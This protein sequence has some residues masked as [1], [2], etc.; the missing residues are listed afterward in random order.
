MSETSNM[1]I[2]IVQML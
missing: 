1:Q 2:N